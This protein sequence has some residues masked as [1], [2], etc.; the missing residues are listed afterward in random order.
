M[1]WV[2]S[3]LAVSGCGGGPSPAKQSPATG[4]VDLPQEDAIS[5][6][7]LVGHH[8]DGRKK[9]QVQGETADL[10]S[11]MVHLS[12]VAAT[13]FGEV[14]VH[15]TSRRG[16]FHKGT[17]DVHLEGDVVVTTSD[18][19][20]LTTE[21]LDW[22]AQQETATTS[23]WVTLTRQGLK[24]VGLGGVG[25]PELKRVR[26]EKQVTVTLEGDNGVTHVTC[27]GPM[28]VDYGRNL[29][30]F[31]KNVRVEDAKG[32]I[33][34]DRLDA[35][36][37]PK[38][39]QLEKATFWGQVRIRQGRQVAHANRANYWQAEGRLRLSGHPKVVML[40]EEEIR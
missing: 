17:Q 32:V 36:F 33:E 38:T 13:S 20:R 39:H 4:R 6:F 5:T 7:T 2:I 34:S 3:L 23:E 29:A 18:G 31:W 14:E 24:A 35:N 1:F 40:P 8:E 19:G 26:L 30:R 37:D 25:Y 27:D 10:L 22:T 9:W 21:Q 11:E 28:E 15:L 12:P 16:R